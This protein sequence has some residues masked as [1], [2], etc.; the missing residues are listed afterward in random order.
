MLK[1]RLLAVS[2]LSAI[3]VACGGSENAAPPAAESAAGQITVPAAANVT[4]ERLLNAA[5]EPGQ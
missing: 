2:T 4:R 5:S 1:Y 3:L